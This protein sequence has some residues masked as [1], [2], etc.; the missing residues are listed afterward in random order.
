MAADRPGAARRR[1][2]ALAVGLGILAVSGCGIGPE[3]V[4][5]I[6]ASGGS[7][8]FLPTPTRTEVPLTVQ[9]FLLRG[10]H[11]VRVSRSVPA[12]S[13]LAPCLTGLTRALNPS[14]VSAGLRT[15]IPV[16]RS[17]PTGTIVDGVAVVSMPSGFDKLSVGGQVDAMSQLVYTITANTVATRVQLSIGARRVS[18]PDGSGQLLSRPVGPSDYAT[19]APAG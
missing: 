11:L 14:D 5:V 16:S 7:T 13:G 17:L 4:P 2:A 19:M 9:V 12:G 15:A 3:Q 1:L 10:E 6:E 18:V 8:P